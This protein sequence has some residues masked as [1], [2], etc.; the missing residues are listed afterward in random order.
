MWV[1][2]LVFFSLS[3]MLYNRTQSVC[4]NKVGLVFSFLLAELQENAFISP[5]IVFSFVHASAP[6]HILTY[7]ATTVFNPN[8]VFE[9]ISMQFVSNMYSD[10]STII[11]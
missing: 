5:S 1:W 3:V 11:L 2:S 4:R 6:I 7:C 10:E 8:L 9:H